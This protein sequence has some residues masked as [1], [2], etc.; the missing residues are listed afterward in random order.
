MA[1]Q[2]PAELEP[3]RA[4]IAQA[5]AL[6]PVT[7]GQA[8]ERGLNGWLSMA[9]SSTRHEAAGLAD[10]DLRDSDHGMHLACDPARMLEGDLTWV[11]A[12]SR[13]V[14]QYASDGEH[15]HLHIQFR[16]GDVG[17]YAQVPRGRGIGGERLEL[18][19]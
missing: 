16:N 8:S 1:S 10:A 11:A 13:T 15:T 18:S 5:V 17:Y 2:A 7:A 3:P 14:A 19:T 4:Q 9:Q 12:A 6:A